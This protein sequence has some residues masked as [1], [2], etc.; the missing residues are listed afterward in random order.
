MSFQIKFTNNTAIIVEEGGGPIMV[1]EIRMGDFVEKFESPLDFWTKEDY[2]A[3]WKNALIYITSQGSKS[4]LITSIYNP[5][6]SNFLRWWVLYRIEND[7]IFQDQIFF[8]NLSKSFDLRDP[9]KS[10]P[11]YRNVNPEGK[12]IS[13]WLISIEEITKFLNQ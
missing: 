9:Y 8:L 11:D 4:C 2:Q 5:K 12:R 3:Q 13:E 7:V 1:G 10:I 6:T